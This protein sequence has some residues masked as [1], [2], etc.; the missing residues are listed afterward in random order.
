[1]SPGFLMMLGAHACSPSHM[2]G[3]AWTELI[4]CSVGN[5]AYRSR[6]RLWPMIFESRFG[7]EMP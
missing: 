5:Q 6:E 7:S 3:R 1:M 4:V 2:P